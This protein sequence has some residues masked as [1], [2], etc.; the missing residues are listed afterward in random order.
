MPHIDKCAG[1][2]YLSPSPRKRG[3]AA[4]AKMGPTAP[5]LPFIS[6]TQRR[7]PNADIRICQ[8]D[9]A[10]VSIQDASP[11]VEMLTR[12]NSQVARLCFPAAA[13]EKIAATPF[14]V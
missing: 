7:H 10:V 11:I 5:L 8:P 6:P 4:R 14:L 12:V 9:G 13:R 2:K 1:T 3:D